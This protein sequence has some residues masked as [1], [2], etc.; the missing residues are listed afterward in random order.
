MP[1][2]TPQQQ[3]LPEGWGLPIGTGVGAAFGLIFGVML[4]QLALG[5]VFGA[6]VG[7]VIGTVTSAGRS[8]PVDRR[9]IVLFT[10][11]AIIAAGVVATVIVLRT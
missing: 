7:L 1:T 11:I 10:A 5:L 9:R 8:L 6:A 3:R 2:Q 4:G